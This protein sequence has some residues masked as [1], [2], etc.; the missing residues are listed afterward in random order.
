MSE[1]GALGIDEEGYQIYN[2]PCCG[3]GV[4]IQPG[5]WNRVDCP[6]CQAQL[7][8]RGRVLTLIG[9]RVDVWKVLAKR[10]L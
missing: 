7:R 5:D 8:Q 4:G 2:A 9:R 6:G 1:V 3:K 10:G